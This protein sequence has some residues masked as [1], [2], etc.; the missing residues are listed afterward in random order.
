[1][2]LWFPAQATPLHLRS[3]DLVNL[4]R[5][6]QF[7]LSLVVFLLACACLTAAPQQVGRAE[8][9]TYYFEEAKQDIE[10]RL[11]VPKS[12]DKE[13]AMPLVVL[14]H[15]LGSTPHQV[16]GY[17]GITAEAE[18]RG[19][20]VVAPYGY[21]TRGWYGSRGDG[22]EGAFFGTKDDPSNLGALSQKDV[23][24][25]LGIVKKEFHIDEDRIY[26]MGH[27]MGGAGTVHLAVTYP[28][29]WAALAPLAPA[30]DDRTSRLEAIKNL[31]VQLVMGDKDRMVSVSLVRKWV[32]EMK[33][34]K[35]D[36]RYE[37]IAGG[38]HVTSI[39]RNAK[40][41]ATVFDFFDSKK[42]I[43]GKAATP[44]KSAEP[45]PKDR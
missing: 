43:A 1:M 22:K 36:Y 31:P 2:R 27:S 3:L 15:G 40:M 14:L 12:Y 39:A 34:L 4:A 7:A 35:M 44:V 29:I 18:K 13:K 11:Y 32:D 20:I 8:K 23:M 9:R 24:N 25:V 16:I 26:L 30:L 17:E 5:F 45:S 42:R 33:K 21:N 10:Y 19:Y 37:E 6:R 28:D 41:I 38:D